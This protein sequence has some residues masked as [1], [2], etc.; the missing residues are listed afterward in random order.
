MNPT[1]TVEHMKVLMMLADTMATLENVTGG[2]EAQDI[3]MAHF[4]AFKLPE[5]V[6][7]TEPSTAS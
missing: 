3:C 2:G 1:L 5:P 7:S 6:K 4:R